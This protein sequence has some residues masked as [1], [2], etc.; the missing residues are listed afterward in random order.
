M[1]IEN[2]VAVTLP[3]LKEGNMCSQAIVS[4]DY[5]TTIQ[6]VPLN[7]TTLIIYESWASRGELVATAFTL[8]PRAE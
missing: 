8:P 6:N 2:T 7:A 5:T 4:L 1:I 3:V